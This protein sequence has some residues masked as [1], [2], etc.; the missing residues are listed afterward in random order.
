MRKSSLNSK[1]L[2]LKV[3]QEAK[4]LLRLKEHLQENLELLLG[5]DLQL[6]VQMI[7]LKKRR[8]KKLP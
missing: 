6:A 1:L 2:L 5:K 4:V 7:S 3:L 8:S